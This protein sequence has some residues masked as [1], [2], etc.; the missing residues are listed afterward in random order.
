MSDRNNSFD[1]NNLKAMQV[2]LASPETIRSWSH[3]EVTK[4]ET[5][6]YRSQKPEM[7]GLFCEKIF[8]PAKDYECHCGKYKK[9]RYQGIVCEKCGVEVTSKEWRRER[10]GHIELVSPCT[11][12]WYLKGIPSRIGLVLD[13]SPKQLEEVV[14]FAAHI[15]IKHGNCTKLKDKQFLDEKTARVVF[16][17]CLKEAKADFIPLDSADQLLADELIEKLQ[18]EQEPFDFFANAELIT[19]YMGVVFGEGAEAIKENRRD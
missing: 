7:G 11:H 1:I 15:V 13:V 10:F 16:V 14:Y 19:K 4:P 17:D 2:G 6:N 18:T 9:I 3:G 8:G 12:I 5:I